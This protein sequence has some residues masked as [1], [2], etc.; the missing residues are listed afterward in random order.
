MKKA[1]HIILTLTFIGIIAG[2]L[3][4]MVSSWA[5]PESK[6]IKKPKQ[7]EQFFL[8][9][10]KEK[11]TSRLRILNLKLTKYLTR[12][13]SLSDIRLLMKVTGFRER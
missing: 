8:F 7:K 4:A 12:I 9:S 13:K 5:S 6:Q 1:L 11:H 3:L 10:P 2:G